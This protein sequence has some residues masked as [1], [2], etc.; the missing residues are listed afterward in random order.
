MV[1]LRFFWVLSLVVPPSRACANARGTE[2]KAN[3]THNSAVDAIHTHEKG[4]FRRWGLF[5][6]GKPVSLIYTPLV[7]IGKK[8]EKIMVREGVNQPRRRKQIFGRCTVGP[9]KNINLFA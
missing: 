3:T 8:A 5:S 2:A 6:M 7:I 1:Y 4:I 9:Y